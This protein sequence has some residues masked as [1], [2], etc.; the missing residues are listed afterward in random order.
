MSTSDFSKEFQSFMQRDDLMALPHPKR[1]DL[2]FIQK[3][4]KEFYQDSIFALREMFQDN[5]KPGVGNQAF[6][7]YPDVIKTLAT[8]GRFS[9]SI[10]EWV[11]SNTVFIL[12]QYYLYQKGTIYSFRKSLLKRLMETDI[13]SQVPAWMIRAPEEASYFEWGEAEKRKEQPVFEAIFE[14]E[15]Q[16]IEGM[17]IFEA[18]HSAQELSSDVCR[19]L[20]FKEGDVVRTLTIMV[21]ESPFLTRNEKRRIVADDCSTYFTLYINNE[22]EPISDMLNRQ[23]GL[24]ESRYSAFTSDEKYSQYKDTFL[25]IMNI[26]IKMLLYLNL[27]DKIAEK[28]FSFSEA[29]KRLKTL[30][31]PGKLKKLSKQTDKLYDKIRIGRSD[32]SVGFVEIGELNAK[33]KGFGS[34][35]EKRKRPHVRRAHFGIRYTEKNRA[36]AKLT[37]I[38]PAIVNEDLIDD[39]RIKDIIRKQYDI[40]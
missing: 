22:M 5:Y 13:D 11:Q 3:I 31:S 35:G 10:D 2:P 37:Y 16:P 24:L 19:Y 25:R 21:V 26:V 29:Q 23:L 7:R 9:S 17:Y 28:E 33:L 18:Q 15:H 12:T 32:E 34:D 36:I 38:K 14:G 39:M 40:F 6:S 8:K 30:K 20:G 27:P 4:Y 1:N